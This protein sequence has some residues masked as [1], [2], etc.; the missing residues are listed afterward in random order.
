MKKTILHF[1]GDLGRGGAETMLVRVLKELPEYNNIVVTL[2]P[3]DHFGKELQCAHYICLNQKPLFGFPILAIRLRRIIRK[4]KVDMVH[5]HLFWPTI[6][7]RMGVPKNIP[8]ITTIHAFIATS[9]EYKIW[10]IRLMDKFSYRLR[11]SVIIGV[12]KG[13]TKEYFSFLNIKPFKSY[14]V[15]TFVDT[16]H[17]K[18]THDESQEEEGIFRLIS[19]GALRVQ[20]NHQYLVEAFRLLKDENIE[21]HIYGRGPLQ[22]KLQKSI[23]ETGVKVILKGQMENL[24]EIL[25]KYNLCVM[26]STFEGFSLG[27]LETMA[28][29]VPMLLSDIV[30]F[31]EQCE[32]TAL[33]FSLDDINDFANKVRKLA[34]DKELRMRLGHEAYNRVISRF[35][36]QHHMDQLR[37]IYMDTLKD[38]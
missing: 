34:A 27:V 13:A 9:V 29:K 31:H 15:Y 1:I 12:A 7:A 3:L 8:L 4:Y 24:H 18:I 32:D 17:F 10:Y 21:L 36:L 33:Y 38:N 2:D 28:T 22:Q 5:T 26:S 16:G 23:D 19:I 20:K 14:A 30:S 25:P 11:R 6:I 35:T 37:R